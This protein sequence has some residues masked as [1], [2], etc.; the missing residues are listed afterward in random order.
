MPQRIIDFIPQHHGTGLIKYFYV[1]ALKR[2]DAEDLVHEEEFRYP[3][4]K[5][6]TIEAAIVML[7]DTVDATAVAKFSN[8]TV[9][10]D[11]LRKNGAGLNPG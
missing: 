3:G 2:A 8:A 9:D 11:D 10:E 5:P 7:A 4:P 6:Q 1:Q